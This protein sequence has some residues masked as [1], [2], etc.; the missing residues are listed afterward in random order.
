MGFDLGFDIKIIL[1]CVLAGGYFLYRGRQLSGVYPRKKL[2]AWAALK[3][4]GL[5]CLLL[6]GLG[7]G[8]NLP[9]GP[10]T[11]LFLVDRSLSVGESPEEIEGYINRQLREKGGREPAG[12]VSFGREP[13]V[14]LPVS[15]ESRKLKLE[16]APDPD[17]TNLQRA[18]EFCRGYFPEGGGKRLVLLTD[19][20]ENLGDAG[21]VLG[22]LGEWGIN[23][24]VLP[25][26]GP[27][28]R[29]VQ[30]TSLGLP[31]SA[32][33]GENIPLEAV[34]TSG[35]DAR[36]V[37][38][39]FCEGRKVLE[40]Q[41]SITK[42]ENRFSFQVLAEG[43]GEA[44]FR[45]EIDFQGDQNPRNDFFT[46]SAP[47]LDRPG[48]LVLGEERE[49]ANIQSLLASLGYTAVGL[50]PGEAPRE[51]GTLAPY[52]GIVLANVPVSQLPG[53][54]Q[55]ALRTSVRE[56]GAGL[57]VLGG[58]NSYGPGGYQHSLLEQ[59][60]PVRC[61]M[62]GNE[63]NPETGLVLAVD[64]SGSMNDRSAG[65]RK[66]DMV[67]EAALKALEV[68][69]EN[70]QLGVLAFSDRLEW[71]VPLG[72]PAR[73]DKIEK[74]VEKLAPGGGTLILPALE[75]ASDVLEQSGAK[76]KHIILLTD[77]QAEKEGYQSLVERL[78]AGKITLSTVAVGQ[79]ADRE[80]LDALAQKGG[81]RSYHTGY[82]RDVPLIFTRETYLAT[83]KYL[84][85]GKY[86]PRPAGAWT[87]PGGGPLPALR[88]Y[89]GTGIKEGAELLL[90]TDTGDPL[91]AR[92][93]YGLGRV[94]AWTPDFSGRWSGDW[95]RWEGLQSFFGPV[96]NNCLGTRDE[97]GLNIKL[98]RR[99]CA[100]EI[101]AAADTPGSGLSLE[102]GVYPPGGGEK[103][104]TLDQTAPGVYAGKL[105]LEQ[106]GSYALDFRLE[107]G[108]VLL[109][110]ARRTVYLD[111]SPEYAGVPGQVPF[112][113]AAFGRVVGPEDNVFALPLERKS[114]SFRKLDCVLLGLALL[115]FTGELWVRK[116]M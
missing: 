107:E 5:L 91:L 42:G 58:E 55:E 80:L 44:V 13:M 93:Q 46:A 87:P 8:V 25:L 7:F 20:R 43:G 97:K 16:A 67:K 85:S 36:G 26:P 116:L 92:W 33:R 50:R 110:Q 105:E 63:K 31:S 111:Y 108:D 3:S 27:G 47:L 14:E 70:D 86:L 62:K 95:L 34:I 69:G 78:N 11:T 12:V 82:Y 75:S 52:A 88:G 98:D 21:P 17:F 54:F 56:Q 103:R 41:L 22:R 49:R 94:A 101:Q 39:L 4:A 102:L 79:D 37:I 99:G 30:L 83:K 15:R 77:G 104:I 114:T 90:E 2:L 89:T 73:R 76:V 64:C 61:R 28:E 45:G 106:T 74:G 32:R 6:A 10:A 9:G 66:I 72:P 35:Y 51:T 59:M 23:L 60:L 1:A 24:A 71:V 18:L 38:S 109:K 29:D 48:V 96:L 115:A 68:L 84:N 19:G 100:V 81:G 40:R 113:P 65:A 53:G 57:L 112:L